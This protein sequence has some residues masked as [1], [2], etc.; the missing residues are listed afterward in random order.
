ME[1]PPYR[2]F[3]V[4]RRS[5]FEA[6]VAENAV[7]AKYYEAKHL[8]SWEK[9]VGLEP[10]PARIVKVWPLDAEHDEILG[11]LRGRGFAV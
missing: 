3:V 8:S 10:G 2:I 5:S 4:G 6:W 9:A 7:A 11:V 1:N